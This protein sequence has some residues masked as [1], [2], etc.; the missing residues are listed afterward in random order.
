VPTGR[1]PYPLLRVTALALVCASSVLACSQVPTPTTPSHP[2][3]LV[4]ASTSSA[5]LAGPATGGRALSLTKGDWT[6]ISNPGRFTLS[7]DEPGTLSFTFPPAP[8]SMNYLY[9]TN[10]PA[11]IG[12]SLRVSVAV[13]T[14]GNPVFRNWETSDSCAAAAHVVLLSGSDPFNA[15]KPFGRW[16]ANPDAYPLSGGAATLSIPS[17]PDRWSS[18]DGRRADA[19][20]V[21]LAGFTAAKASVSGLGLTF[22]GCFFGH[23]VSASGGTATFVLTEFSIQP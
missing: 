20:A 9:H 14:I 1:A 21:T 6:T 10:P 11:S 23:G 19:D 4:G 16:W 13:R 2:T 15:A 18:A 17:T 22:G 3:S 7:N 12:G 5:E 8:D